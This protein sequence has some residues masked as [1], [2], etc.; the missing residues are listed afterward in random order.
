MKGVAALIGVGIVFMMLG[1]IMLGLNNFRSVEVT[2]PYNVTTGGAETTYTVTL[3][4]DVLD[5]HT[6]N[7]EVISDDTDDAPIP[8]TWTKATKQLLVS[9]LAE[10]TTRTLTVTYKVPQLD[11]FTDLAARFLPMFIML[12]GIGIVVGSAIYAFKNRD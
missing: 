5:D 8:Y 12:G 2:A 11:D 9:G 1:A 4:N 10:S 3:A 6:Y 7:I